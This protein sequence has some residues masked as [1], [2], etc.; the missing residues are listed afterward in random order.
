M[1]GYG[2]SSADIA[3]KKITVEIKSL[4][5]K[6]MDIALKMPLFVREKEMEIRNLIASVLE[7]GKVDFSVVYENTDANTDTQLNFEAIKSHYRNLKQLGDELGA[8]STDYLNLIFK[9]PDVFANNIGELN[10]DEWDAIKSAITECLNNVDEYRKA[11][12]ETI[13]NDFACRITNIGNLLDNVSK[14]EANRIEVIKERLSKSLNEIA[15]ST[16][17][18][19]NRFEQE[20]IYYIEKIDIN[21]EKVR[22]RQHLEY[23]VKTVYEEQSQ[24]KKLLFIAQEMGREINTLGSKAND[25][26]IQQIVV[27][28]KDELEKIKEQLGNVL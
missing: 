14:F 12:G 10:D 4:N 15:D 1:T 24:G 6:Q 2:K 20:L 22:L 13:M 17:V 21:E 25:F 19:A 8:V 11:E 9:L 18:D 28:M 26:N 16:K 27:Q 3:G 7:R 23:F 5:S